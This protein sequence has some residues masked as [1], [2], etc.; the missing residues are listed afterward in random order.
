MK[1]TCIMLR[2]LCAVLAFGLTALAQAQIQTPAQTQTTTTAPTPSPT[3]AERSFPSHPIRLV[4][5]FAP[6]ATTDILSRII[7]EHMSADWGQPVLVE[8]RPGSTGMIGT[9]LVARAAPDGYTLV[10]VISSHVVLKNLLKQVPFDPIKDFTPVILLART[11]LV[12]V[13]NPSVPARTVPEFIAWVN[14]QPGGVGYGT[15]GIGSAVH[16]TTELFKQQANVNLRHIPYKGGAPALTDLLGGHVKVVTSAIYTV[17]PQLRDGSVIPIAVA[18]AKRQPGY[19]N[20]PTLVESGYPGVVNDE[21]WAILAPAGTPRPIVD[22]LNAEIIKIFNQQAVQKKLAGLNI[23]Y[24]GGSPDQLKE[25]MVSQAAYWEK[26]I[27][28]ADIQPQ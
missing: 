3:P 8:N 27:K 1:A 23:E 7:S 21:W 4:T 2:G 24:V 16:L 17:T 6:G 15:S 11:P 12:I 5:P 19:E 10:N 28:A 26:V 22:K 9:E 20:V 25:Y 13:V 18:S 14:A